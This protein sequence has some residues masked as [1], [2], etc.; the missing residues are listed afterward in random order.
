M[1]VNLGFANVSMGISG[2]VAFCERFP[3]ISG[4]QV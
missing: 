2:I 3:G 4:R 1:S